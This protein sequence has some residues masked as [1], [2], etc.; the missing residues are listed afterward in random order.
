[1][2][3]AKKIITLVLALSLIASMF[4]LFGCSGTTTA[5]MYEKMQSFVTNAQ[6]DTSF[7]DGNNNFKN[8]EKYNDNGEKET[9]NEAQNKLLQIVMPYITTNI[10]K[11]DG[12]TENHDY[13]DLEQ[14][15]NALQD[16]FTEGQERYQEMMLFSQSSSTDQFIYNGFAVAYQS[17]CIDFLNKAYQFALSLQDTFVNDRKL[18]D[19]DFS[20]ITV[21]Q[22]NFYISTIK[23]SLA[24]DCRMALLDSMQ[25]EK[26]NGTS[27][28]ISN[29][30]NDVD[31][32]LNINNVSST[33]Q[34]GEVYTKL[35]ELESI[36]AQ[37]RKN[38][39]KALSSF[40][41]YAFEYDYNSRINNYANE[42]ENAQVYY[43]VIYNYFY[44]NILQQSY[45]DMFLQQLATI[46]N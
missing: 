42:L 26:S 24:D 23:L 43:D 37:E 40:S 38:L 29:V 1:M 9:L 5:Q 30:E 41:L 44:S 28:I 2:V 39:Q 3:K 14:K 22:A 19:I 27:S 8:F 12:Y 36:M 33:E 10:T 16:A 21:D 18:L 32:I 46:Y 13:A 35:R 34:K 20:Q 45:M 25:G 4:V 15:L 7:V 6:A 11:F 31:A 17:A